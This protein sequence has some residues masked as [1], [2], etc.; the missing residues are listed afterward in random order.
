MTSSERRVLV[1][2]HDEDVRAAVCR[3]LRDRGYS[4][5]EAANGKDALDYVVASR[6][7]E[8]ALIVL[9]LELPVMSGADFLQIV[10]SYL[11]LAAIPVVV[12]GDAPPA[13]LLR[14]GSIAGFLP[15]PVDEHAL[16]SLVEQ[17]AR[18]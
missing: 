2:D 12:V 9:Q 17:H 3:V 6:T 13:D 16:L 4:V 11:R 10:K 7:N 15:K 14:V 1:V 8:P 18:S 5:V